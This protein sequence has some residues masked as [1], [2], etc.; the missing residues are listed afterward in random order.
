MRWLP[1]TSWRE[2]WDAASSLGDLG[3]ATADYLGGLAPRSPGY[4]GPPN[5]E[6]EL[7]RDD[8]QAINRRGFVTTESQP[9]HLPQWEDEGGGEGSWWRQRAWVEGYCSPAQAEVIRRDCAANGLQCQVEPVADMRKWWERDSGEPTWITK[10]DGEVVTGVGGRHKRGWFRKDWA[11]EVGEPAY[12]A[13]KRSVRVT[14]VDPEWGRE[15]TLW[16]TLRQ[17]TGAAPRQAEPAPQPEAETEI[18]TPGSG[19]DRDD[20]WRGDE[21]DDDR[22]AQWQVE[23]GQDQEG[24]VLDVEWDTEQQRGIKPAQRELEWER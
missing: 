1:D 2:P 15:R 20:R 22:R 12:Q 19:H 24:E 21:Q 23:S 3:D 13:L 8:L 4:L 7:I 17:S 18:E 6:T 5:P 14:V 10:R 16:D 11:G 9:G